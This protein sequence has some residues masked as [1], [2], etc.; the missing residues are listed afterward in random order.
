MTEQEFKKTNDENIK[1]VFGGVIKISFLKECYYSVAANP[2]YS[3]V[4]NKNIQSLQDPN[5]LF[6][7]FDSPA[8]ELMKIITA[9]HTFNIIGLSEEEKGNKQRS[10]EYK[11]LLCNEVIKELKASPYGPRVKD[12]NSFNSYSPAFYFCYVTSEYIKEK[13]MDKEIRDR[14]LDRYGENSSLLFNLLMEICQ[15]IES[16]ITILEIPAYSQSLA[17]LRSLIDEYFVFSVIAC[18]PKATKDYFQ[19]LE[20]ANY[21]DENESYS[22]EFLNRYQKLKKKVSKLDYLH[23]GWLDSVEEYSS[24][25]EKE[26]KVADLISLLPK[27]KKTK[28]FFS[29]QYKF[30]SKFIH[31]NYSL[32]NYNR[33]DAPLFISEIIHYILIDVA[34]QYEGFTESNIEI[35]DIKIIDLLLD[36]KNRIID[37]RSKIASN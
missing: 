33:T 26:Y 20:Y 28:D 24:K 2:Y 3:G 25:E 21:Y 7:G 17:L 23:Y 10:E 35:E 13:M 29:K 5:K 11:N 16:I 9:I 37:E 31:G 12:N 14:L 18:N 34:N 32:N 22:N 15:D 1:R 27:D 8:F 19:F 36:N 4:I 30:L 6:T